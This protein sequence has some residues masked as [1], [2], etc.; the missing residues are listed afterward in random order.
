MSMG[1]QKRLVYEK[2]TQV[3]ITNSN[4]RRPQNDWSGMIAYCRDYITR[5][6]SSRRTVLT[7]SDENL[8]SFAFSLSSNTCMFSAKLLITL[9]CY[10]IYAK[11]KNE[12]EQGYISRHFSISN[13]NHFK[14]LGSTIL[15]VNKSAKHNQGELQVTGS[16]NWHETCFNIR[17]I[18]PFKILQTCL[19]FS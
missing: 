7:Y 12:S 19:H 5:V 17:L 10:G 11:S 9:S 3:Y 6:V 16:V 13:W 18:P 1:Q 2:L 14:Q 15:K 8:A 4:C